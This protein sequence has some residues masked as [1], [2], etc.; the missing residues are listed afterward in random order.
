MLIVAMK[1]EGSSYYTLSD[2]ANFGILFPFEYTLR[3]EQLMF[4]ERIAISNFGGELTIAL[5]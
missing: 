5:K 3:K 1:V 2:L 4:D